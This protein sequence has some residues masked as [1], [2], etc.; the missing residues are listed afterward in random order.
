VRIAVCIT[1]LLGLAGCSIGGDE[2]SIERRDLAQVVLQPDDVPRVFFRFDYGRQIA[3]DLPGGERADPGRFEREDG[4]KA[5]F[6]RP[7]TPA[8][9]GPLV[10]ESRVDLFAS[11]GGA[12]ED[13]D[14]ARDELAASQLGWRAIDEPG[15]GDESFAAT[16]VQHGVGRVRHYQVFW[17]QDN[18][19]ASVT[20][21][22]FEGNFALAD[23]LELARKQERRIEGA[24]NA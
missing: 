24:A 15:L 9:A 7:G 14:A 1:A 16:F 12:G 8:T 22:G 4:W 19:T 21:N 18:A 11:A 5:R 13:L 2:A 23:V 6:R 17:R 10:I 3:A 20:A